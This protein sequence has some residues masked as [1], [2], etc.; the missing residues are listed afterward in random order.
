MP[1]PAGKDADP[2]ESLWDFEGRGRRLAVIGARDF[3][4]NVAARPTC[5]PRDHRPDRNAAPPGAA[6]R[7]GGRRSGGGVDVLVD[8][9][10]VLGVVLRLDAREA[11]VVVA[12]G[13]ADALLALVH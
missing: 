13:G 11:V 12:V 1:A 8:R 10:D 2:K 7:S 5:A 6:M 3:T 4:C 9:E